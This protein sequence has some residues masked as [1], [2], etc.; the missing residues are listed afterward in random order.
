MH[1]I[2]ENG[3]NKAEVNWL[4]NCSA[5]KACFYR[6]QMG[7]YLPGYMENHERR[8]LPV[9][10]EKLKNIHQMNWGLISS[11]KEDKTK[12]QIGVAKVTFLH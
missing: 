1:L 8:L 6:N 11:F 3:S 4:G 12:I 7:D 10:V 2:G 5:Q 9:S